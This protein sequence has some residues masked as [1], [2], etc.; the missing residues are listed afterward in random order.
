MV[1]DEYRHRGV[2][3]VAALEV[4]EEFAAPA[5]KCPNILLRYKV[6][7]VNLYPFIGE[8]P[9]AENIPVNHNC[10]FAEILR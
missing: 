1:C 3:V 5:D 8:H 2:E 7:L 10:L 9:A 6:C 4:R